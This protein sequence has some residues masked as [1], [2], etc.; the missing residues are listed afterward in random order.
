MGWPSARA[1]YDHAVAG[2]AEP[3]TARACAVAGVALAVAEAMGVS[4]PPLALLSA[5]GPPADVEVPVGDASPWLPG[6]VNE[7][8]LEPEGR[9][10]G[11]AFYTPPAVASTTVEWALEGL[12]A[13]RPVV[14]DPGVGGGAFLLAAADAL[15]ARGLSRTE[16]VGGCLT[17]ADIDPVSVAVTEAALALWCEGRAVPRV[18]VGDA[19]ALDP[20]DW[21]ARPDAVVANPPFLNQLGRATARSR[22]VTPELRRR[23]GAVSGGYADTAALFLVLA[24]RLV[25][26]GGTAALVLPESF[27]A[28]RDTQAARAAVLAD[29]F[30]EVL[31]LPAQ[32]VFR[33][34]VAVCV[35][36]L[37]RGGRRRGSLRHFRGLPAAPAATVEADADALALAPT[38][39]HLVATGAGVPECELDCD[40]TLGQWCDVAADFRQQYYGVAPFV[41]DDPDDLLDDR[42]CPR[43]V[44]CGLVDPASCV[45]GR[46]ATRHHRQLW[47]AP[48]VDLARLEAESDLGPWARARLVP[49]VVVATQTRVVEAAVDLDGTW[50]PSTPLVTVVTS[51]ERLWHA[52]AALL[53]PP[54]TAWALRTWGGTALS[55]N[56]IKLSAAQVRAV[57]APGCRGAWDQAAVAVRRACEAGDG[58][59]RRHWLLIAAEASSRA[60]GVADPAVLAWWTA[61]LDS[62]R[63][64]SPGPVTFRTAGPPRGRRPPAQVRG[65]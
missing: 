57:P 15:A 27:L 26:P 58:G 52:A 33:A 60:Y 39:S 64:P 54:V 9:R 8:L 4:L 7:A 25:R 14:C 13:S 24:A 34:G 12:A 17:G 46:R 38:W 30:L 23:F 1:A 62:G 40:G 6:A 45:W 53:A 22:A 3:S 10:S 32:P 29:A 2:G 50:L 47:R 44:T 51:G 28:A 61:R 5:W 41:V 35:V 56:A 59:D 31:W 42:C 37:R 11:G 19:L 48:R 21:P 63:E 43:L 55:S 65:R 20:H 18:L 16:V 49:K 36:V